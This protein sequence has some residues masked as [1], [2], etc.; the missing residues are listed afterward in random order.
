MRPRA[1]ARAL[2]LCTA[3]ALLASIAGV[4]PADAQ[5]ATAQVV[6]G[7]KA[8]GEL[9]CAP[10]GS[11][12]GVGLTEQHVAAVVV[13]RAAGPSGPIRPVPGAE[14]L[15]SITCRPGGSC[16]AV[17]ASGPD[18]SEGRRGVVVEVSRDG[19][20]GPVRPVSGSGQLLDVDC[21]TATTCVAIGNLSANIPWYPY[22]VSTPVFTIIENGQP[23]PAR[24]LPRRTGL[25]FGL[26]CPSETTCLVVHQGGFVVLRRSN[27]TWNATLRRVP[28]STG[29][30]VPAYDI[31]CSSSTV[32]YATATAFIPSGGGYYAVPAIMP[33]SADGVAGRVQILTTEA[34]NAYDISCTVGR[35]CTAVGGSNVAT[36]A[37]VVDVFR[38][39]PAAVTTW[40]NFSD[41]SGVSCVGPA[42]CGMV[43]GLGN[44]AYFVWHGP[45]PG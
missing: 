28:L 9:W 32:C 12:L 37:L 5:Q 34:G 41:F 10:D 7:M 29:G 4:V 15:S 16:I 20:P 36:R 44:T 3:A 18:T 38:G 45:V 14:N 25:V 13:L 6:P 2:L 39:T 35:A 31:S 22:S 19:I 24:E 11:C 26:A 43:G 42:T 30:A 21:P 17:G 40:P 27:G 23:A 33:V 8:V 1:A